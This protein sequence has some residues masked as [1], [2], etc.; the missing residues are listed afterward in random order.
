MANPE[1]GVNGACNLN[2]DMISF[3]LGLTRH[4]LIYLEVIL[5]YLHELEVNRGSSDISRLLQGVTRPL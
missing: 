2:P 4:S 3:C 5:F 1:S